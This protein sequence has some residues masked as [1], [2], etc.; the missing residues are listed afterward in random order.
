MIFKKIKLT[1]HKKLKNIRRQDHLIGYSFNKKNIFYKSFLPL[2]ERV[3][4]IAILD[5][6]KIIMYLET[7]GSIA[8]LE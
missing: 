5:D 8:I 7:T 4:D 2:K 6:N 1:S 3:R